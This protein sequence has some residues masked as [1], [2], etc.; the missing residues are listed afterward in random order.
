MAGAGVKPPTFC[1]PTEPP[2][3]PPP[4]PEDEPVR[5]G[6]EVGLGFVIVVALLL[7]IML[8]IALHWRFP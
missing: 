4:L 8:G 1:N 3:Y 5:I 7:L 6:N 2:P